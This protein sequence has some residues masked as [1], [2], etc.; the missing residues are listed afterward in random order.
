[1]CD[2]F[3]ALYYH[4]FQCDFKCKTCLIKYDHRNLIC[5][6]SSY[7]TTLYEEKTDLHAHDVSVYKQKSLKQNLK[8]LFM[9]VQCINFRYIYA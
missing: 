2:E 4:A 3:W 7:I 6:E 5:E 8:I 9:A 1:M